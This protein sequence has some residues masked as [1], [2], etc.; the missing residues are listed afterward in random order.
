M[1]RSTVSLSMALTL[2]CAVSAALA[3]DTPAANPAPKYPDS[4]DG[5]KKLAEDLYALAKA[6]DTEKLEA[7]ARELILSDP[8]AW[9]EKTFTDA[10]MAAKVAG[11]LGEVKKDAD[12]F[13]HEIAKLF[14]DRVE[15]G[16]SEISVLRVENADDENA[17]GAQKRVLAAMKAPTALYTVKFKAPDAEAGF[18]LWSFVYVDNGFRLIGKLKSARD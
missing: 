5:L 11:E 7:A 18:S 13:A 15:K 17:T 12:R 10:S 2:L 3:Q 9:A 4:A 8:Q 16:Q 6:G 14:A 1:L